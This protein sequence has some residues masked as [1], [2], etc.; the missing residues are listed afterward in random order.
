[1]A[2]IEVGL[3]RFIHVFPCVSSRNGPFQE[4]A[5]DIQGVEKASTRL[6]QAM[7]AL[8]QARSAAATAWETLLDIEARSEE[9]QAELNIVMEGLGASVPLKASQATRRGAEKEKAQADKLLAKAHRVLGYA[10]RSFG[11]VLACVGYF[12]GFE[13]GTSFRIQGFR[14]QNSFFQAVVTTSKVAEQL[15]QVRVQ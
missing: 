11:D 6:T 1:M 13:R 3:S 2:L 9:C 8:R 4:Q 15:N 5:V 10:A 7:E 12:E 14:A